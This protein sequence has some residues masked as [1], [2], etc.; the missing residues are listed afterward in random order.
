[1][2]RGGEKGASPQA[3]KKAFDVAT[4][5]TQR[6]WEALPTE[7][8]RKAAQRF[9]HDANADRATLLK[10]LVRKRDGAFV[11][12]CVCVCCL[13]RL[14]GRGIRRDILDRLI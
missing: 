6:P 11:V 3:A 13:G 10:E 4:T 7:E 2:G 1:M 9:G 12:A 14:A 5:S 8:L